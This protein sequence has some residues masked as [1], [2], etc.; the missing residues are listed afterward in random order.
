MKKKSLLFVGM[1]V[2]ALMLS[3]SDDDTASDNLINGTWEFKLMG[4]LIDGNE[5]MEAYEHAS[6]C[7]KDEISFLPRGVYRK[8]S[9]QN[10]GSGCELFQETGSWSL[11]GNQLVL[12]H[13]DIV[14]LI[15]AEIITLNTSALKFKFSEYDEGEDI[16]FIYIFELVKK[17]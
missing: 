9:F 14:E 10:E 8:K 6:G 13:D 12:V 7:S 16:T 5:I 17:N 2:S 3:C 4:T 11:S 15:N 1:F